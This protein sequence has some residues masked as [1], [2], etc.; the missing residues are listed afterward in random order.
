MKIKIII[1]GSTG[2]IGKST[3][4]VA[5]KFPSE[6][7]II[8]LSTNKNISLLLRQSKKFKVKNLIINNKKIFD[9]IKKKKYKKINIFNSVDE[10]INKYKTKVDNVIVGVSG[11]DGLEPTL[12][13]I[14]Y[15]KTVS[16][17]NKE[18]ILCG[19]E[20]INKELK[21]NKTNFI[22]LDSEHFSI[23]NLINSKEKIAKIYLTASGGPFLNKKNSAIKNIMPKDALKH[24]NWKMGKKISIDSATMMNKIFEII[25]AIKI[26][27]IP[28]NKFEI[29]IHPESY[30]HAIIDFKKGYTKFLAHK[31]DM[32]I[33]IFNSIFNNKNQ[34]FYMNT[35]LNINKI[36]N[37]NFLKPDIE[38]Y[39]FLKLYSKIKNNNSYFEI[40]LLTINDYLV[41]L[42]LQNKIRYKQFQYKLIKLINDQYFKKY[43]NKSPNNFND[44]KNMKKKVN[45]Y[46]K[47]NI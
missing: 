3:L 9:E 46:I 10:Y 1:L 2:S 13:L 35:K 44:L 27:N 22:P 40:I 38:K 8:C 12:K 32:Q 21:K 34:N 25:E 33:P 39:P 18:S 36:N 4:K 7:E 16:S 19:W 29:I 31:T 20:L 43:Y 26:F 11:F 24:P 47:N 23:W 45:V 30:I 14:P 41:E 37:I 5:E 15:A 6:I 28:R 42:Y 17:A